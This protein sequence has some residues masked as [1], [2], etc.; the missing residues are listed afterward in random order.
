MVRL[1]ST[2]IAV[3]MVLISGS[4]GAVLY[5]R[6]GFTGSEAAIAGIA[7]LS[8][9]A[10][11][12]TVTTRVQDRSLVSRQVADLSRGTADLARQVGEL[13]RRVY[14]FETELGT[15]VMKARS[16]TEPLSAEIGMLGTLVKQI[17]DSVSA[18]DAVLARLSRPA[19]E[20]PPQAAAPARPAAPDP[21]PAFEP[22]IE[23]PEAPPAMHRGAEGTGR[24][25]GVAPEKVTAIIRRAI[26]ANRVDLYMQPIVTLPQRKVRYYEASVRLRGDDGELLLPGDFLPHA[27]SGGLMPAIDNLL[28]FRCVQVIRRMQ[29]KNREVGLFCNISGA[30]ISDASFPQLAEF[31]EANRALSTSIVLEFA[32]KTVR[33]LGPIELASLGQIVDLGFRFSMDRLADLNLE[34]REFSERGFRFVKAPAELLLRR[35]GT[36]SDIHPA[37]FSDLLGRFGID[38][39]ADKIESESTVVDLL[40]YDVRFGQGTLFSPPRPV[41]N[42]VLQGVSDRPLPASGRDRTGLPGSRD[43]AAPLRPQPVPADARGGAERRGSGVNSLVRGVVRRDQ[44]V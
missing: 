43:E 20:P 32:Q 27:E 38:L 1:A 39:I 44:R 40:D 17:A 24:F 15:A 14:A 35:G 36:V 5:L 8:G 10:L 3:C 16:A 12:N 7:A 11:V 6:F 13:G 42:E 33:S 18:H 26:E 28:L 29:T 9:L 31:L 25:K 4:L 22:P 41:R 37:D 23:E 34:P 19:T 2:F 21:L 30:T